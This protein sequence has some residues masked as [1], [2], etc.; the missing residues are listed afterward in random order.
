MLK[1]LEDLVNIIRD[2]KSS[3][4]ASSYTT[5]L[6]KDK[7]LSL[8]K[9]KEEVGELVEAVENNSNK[10]LEVLFRKELENIYLGITNTGLKVVMNKK[11]ISWDN[12]NY[13]INLK[14]RYNVKLIGLSSMEDTLRVSLKH[15]SENPWN[16][17]KEKYKKINV[18]GHK[19]DSISIGNDVWIASNVVI[20]KGVS[21]GD[22][23]VI[24]AGSV[25]TKSIDSYTVVAG[26]PAKE[27]SKRN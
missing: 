8:E 10:V 7:S 25:V 1:T 20:L 24:A 21:I 26:V 23:S 12:S 11:D 16:I 13:E 6:L 14:N 19:S 27:I 3:P 18:Q 22:G 5:K 15:N 2:R 17:F 9:V 4:D